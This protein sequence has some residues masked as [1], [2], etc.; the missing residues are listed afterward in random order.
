MHPS[1][2]TYRV[3]CAAVI[4]CILAASADAQTEAIKIVVQEGE[5][6]INNVQEHRAKEPVIQVLHEDGEPV[7]GASVIFQLPDD[8]PGGIFA[9]NAKMLSVQTDEK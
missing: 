8:G 6:A 3:L 9:D 5:G 7:A 2:M 4:F 1:C